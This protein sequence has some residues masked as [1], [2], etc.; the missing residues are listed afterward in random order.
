[1]RNANMSP[2]ERAAEALEKLERLNAEADE[3]TRRPRPLTPPSVADV[4][5]LARAVE[6]RRSRVEASSLASEA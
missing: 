1:M 5:N 6:D 4:C 3:L 2:A